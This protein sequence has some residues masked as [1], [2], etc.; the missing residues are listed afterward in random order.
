MPVVSQMEWRFGHQV[1]LLSLCIRKAEVSVMF[2]AGFHDHKEI[3]AEQGSSCKY[4]YISTRNS[5]Q[6]SYEWCIHHPIYI[7]FPLP[8][9]PS[10]CLSPFV[11][12]SILLCIEY[13]RLLL[14]ESIGEA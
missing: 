5:F 3:G 10:L 6:K 11:S 8:N 2:S 7:V 14:R 1:A 4:C 13:R 12:G 9:S